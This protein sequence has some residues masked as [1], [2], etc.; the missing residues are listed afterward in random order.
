MFLTSWYGEIML[1]FLSLPQVFPFNVAILLLCA[2]TVL[3]ILGALMMGSAHHF[4]DHLIP[5]TDYSV[6]DWIHLG[7][8]PVMVLL[9]I[10]LAG[11]ACG[12]HA[13][14]ATSLSFLGAYLPVWVACTA[15]A[16]YGL[17]VVHF[18]GSLVA[19]IIPKDQTAAVSE[20]ELIGLTGH[21]VTGVARPGHPAELKVIDKHGNPHYLMIEPEGDEE[22]PQ[23][24]AVIVG[25]KRDVFFVGK[26]QNQQS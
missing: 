18:L 21:I 13:L 17:V 24:S 14:Q 1:E 19:K 4:L 25:P 10:F 7:R 26:S 12:G 20:V 16:V 11:F 3:E 23:G 2:L 9:I 6:L 15:S 8:V 22:F 5:D